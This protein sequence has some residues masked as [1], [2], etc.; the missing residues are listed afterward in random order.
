MCLKNASKSQFCSHQF[1]RYKP[2][3]KGLSLQKIKEKMS[4]LKMQIWPSALSFL[5]TFCPLLPPPP[6]LSFQLC[7]SSNSFSL[8]LILMWLLSLS[9]PSVHFFL[10]S[11]SSSFNPPPFLLFSFFFLKNLPL[12][13]LNSLVGSFF[14]LCVCACLRVCGYVS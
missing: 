8:G 1:G 10:F 5:S 6:V 4:I 2:A 12:M 9:S 11:S 3:S 7:P 14:G 13:K